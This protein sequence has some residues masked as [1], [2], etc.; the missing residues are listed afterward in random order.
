[1]IFPKAMTRIRLIIPSRDLLDVTKELAHQ[2]VLHQTDGHYP[3]SEKA[4][5]MSNSWPEKAATYAALE[6]R[7]M[8]IIQ[9]LGIEEGPPLYTDEEPLVDIALVRPPVE[10]IDQEVKQVSE[11]MADEQKRLEQLDNIL[12]Q[13]EPIA[14]IAVDLRT[15]RHPGYIYSIFGVMPA[16]NVD[17]L[18]TSLARIPF[19]LVTLREENHR[20][21]VWLAGTR[22]N[23]DILDRAARSAYLNP[24]SLPE[25][26]Q[27]TPSEIIESLQADIGRVQQHISEQKTTLSRLAEERKQQLQS[28]LWQVRT[29]RTLAEA[30]GRFGRSRYTYLIEGWVPSSEVAGFSKQLQQVSR[31]MFIETAAYTR[32]KAKQN[33]PVALNN[34]RLIRSFQDLVVNYARPRYDEVDPTFLLAFTFPILFGAM[35]GDVGHGLALTLLGW[36]LTSR[37]V[38]ALH[39]LAGLGGLLTTCGLAATLFGFV[40]GSLFGLESVLPTLWIRPM[41]NITQILAVAIV[42]G[43]VLLSIGFLL[44]ILNAWTTQDWGRLF[45]DRRGLAG[46][47]LYWSL[48]G[49]AVEAI[50]GK[51]PVHAVVLVVAAIVAGLTVMFSEILEHL[52]Q[53]HRPLVESDLGTYP[54]QASFELFETLISYLS[55]SLSYVRVG[56]FAVAH[57]GLSAVVLILAGLVSPEQGAGYWI[58]FALGNLFIIGFEGLIVSIQTLRLEYY[59]FFNRF[60]TGGGMHYEP[61]SLLPK[62]E[63]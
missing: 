34:P 24:L 5:R 56:A 33:V 59:E 28:L 18:Q 4:F 11:Q 19:V 53:G 60:F 40:Y 46:L 61:L 2:Q 43:V 17:R 22:R 29:S 21:V 13:L 35:F 3:D 7:I 16:A 23:A 45:F 51:W 57:V 14:G 42:A 47:V 25:V 50:A 63:E 9:T 55:N 37:K 54:I 6:R 49:L 62:I 36:L 12:K 27:G 41:N 31:N 30:M 10:Q 32:G 39:G 52:I 15:M 26:Y 38:P 44:S 58:V 20:A 1:M 8:W 48:V